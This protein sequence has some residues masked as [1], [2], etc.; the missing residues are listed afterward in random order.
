MVA[1]ARR[2]LLAQKKNLTDSRRRIRIY[3]E[4]LK[5]T[6]TRFYGNPASITRRRKTSWKVLQGE[7]GGVH[8]KEGK[9]RTCYRSCQ[10]REA[11]KLRTPTSFFPDFSRRWSGNRM[12]AS[13]GNECLSS[14]VY[15]SCDGSV[16]PEVRATPE[17]S[18]CSQATNVEFKCSLLDADGLRRP[19]WS[20]RSFSCPCV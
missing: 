20:R 11:K 12:R 9:E 5:G 1:A 4:R 7:V 8:A 16:L 19:F 10:T 3:V 14:P 18:L 2:R 13:C 15:S 17:L 6:Y